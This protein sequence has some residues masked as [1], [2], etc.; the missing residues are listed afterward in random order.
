MPVLPH[1]QPS[2]SSLVDL[3]QARPF[4]DRHIGPDADA[5]AKMLAAV[6]YGS[7]TS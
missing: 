2:P 3:E 1:A 7:S 4:A 6:G 5:Q